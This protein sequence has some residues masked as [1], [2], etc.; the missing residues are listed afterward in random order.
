MLTKIHILSEISSMGKMMIGIDVAKEWIDVAV[1][2][3]RRVRRISNN[4]QAIDGWLA[5]TGP[6]S[7]GLVAF[8]P[9][10]GYERPAPLSQP[11]ASCL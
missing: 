3:E 6:G 8:E 10:G 2:G 9:T 5:E 4:E 7:I 11:G 1:A